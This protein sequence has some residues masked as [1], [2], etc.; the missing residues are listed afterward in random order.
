MPAS[1][2]Q[3]AEDQRGDS[4]SRAYLPGNHSIEA[5]FDYLLQLLGLGVQHRLKLLGLPVNFFVQLIDLLLHMLY[6]SFQA[7]RPI[8][9]TKILN[10]V[11]TAGVGGLCLRALR[12]PLRPLC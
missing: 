10:S 11:P 6:L 4:D 8:A 9:N 12:D 3:A 7:G 1:A 5:L 2:R